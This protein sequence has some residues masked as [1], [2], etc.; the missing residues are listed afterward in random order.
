M[1]IFAKIKDPGGKPGD[2][3]EAESVHC[4]DRPA[5]HVAQDLGGL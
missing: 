3:V 1:A 4:G 5:L 2:S